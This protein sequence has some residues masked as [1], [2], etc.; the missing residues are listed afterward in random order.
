MTLNSPNDSQPIGDPSTDND[1]P[2]DFE[3]AAVA[4]SGWRGVLANLAIPFVVIAAAVG[5]GAVLISSPPQVPKSEPEALAPVV[6]LSELVAHD[7][8]VFVDAFGTVRAAREIRIAPEV[9]GRIIELNPRLEP[10]G[11]I[12]AGE[13]LFKIDPADYAIA[14]AQAQA[15][16]DVA[17]HETSRIRARIETLRGRGRQLDVEIDYLKWNADRLGRLAERDSVAQLEA[18]DAVTRFESQ[19][20]ARQSLNAEIVEQEKAVESAIAGARVVERRLETAKLALERTKVVAPFDAI[21]VTENVEQGQLIQSQ[22]PVA[23]LA[24]TDEFWAEAAIPVSRLVD[25]RFAVEYPDNPSRV[26]VTMATG[27]DAVER[28]GV[29][30]RP[31][32]N[33]DPL[34]RM[35]RVLVS[36]LDPL[37]L[38]ESEGAAARRVLLGSYVRLRI[39]SGTL[40]EVYAIPRKALREND[41]I[42]VRNEQGQLA[43]RPVKIVWRRHDDVLVRNGFQ[44]GDEL[45]TTHLASVVPGMPLRIREQSLETE[46]A[47]T[48]HGA[49]DAPQ[50]LSNSPTSATP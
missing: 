28:Q 32:G 36:I 7:V 26:I 39:E 20:A 5:I 31:L 19:K 23:T 42:W 3:H 11:L 49:G 50:P 29:A 35:A 15:D 1:N 10:G 43:I 46:T 34:G 8:Q 21:V 48:D 40:H 4:P 12:S 38:D 24:A 47:A 22:S 27:S 25:L 18:R 37:G 45:V 44:S 6:G 33:L 41:R 14:V 13:E 2:Q 30:L 9:S 16:L 17:E